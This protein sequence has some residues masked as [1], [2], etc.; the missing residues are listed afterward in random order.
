MKSI[1]LIEF[2]EKVKS[3]EKWVILDGLVIDVKSFISK[4]PGGAQILES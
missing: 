4:H 2:N 3:G 1:D